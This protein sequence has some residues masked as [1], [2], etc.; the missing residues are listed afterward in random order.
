MSFFS[1]FIAKK[2][3]RARAEEPDF[4]HQQE[5]ERAAEYPDPTPMA[6]PIGYKKQPSIW[7]QQKEMI[8][9]IRLEEH[10]QGME[11]FEEADDF[12]VD[13]DF[14]PST[15]FEKGFDLSEEPPTQNEPPQAAPPQPVAAAPPPAVPE[16]PKA[17]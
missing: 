17:P 5:V 9:R 3:D 7:A 6:P 4:E 8:R 14:E 2:I 1:K 16:P 12:D 11:T 15:P 10:D 13:D